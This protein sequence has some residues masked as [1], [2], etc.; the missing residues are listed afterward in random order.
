MV[1]GLAIGVAVS[2][3]LAVALA[4]ARH[5]YVRAVDEGAYA[6]FRG[7]ENG[8][9]YF[10]I[11]I[12]SGLWP[13]TLLFLTGRWF[14]TAVIGRPTPKQRAYAANRE[15]LVQMRAAV[16]AGLIDEVPQYLLDWER[17]LGRLR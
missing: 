6:W 9:S 7:M 8:D 4:V 14:G 12:C 5:E 10:E 15:A 13:I 3:Y 2:A 1:E 11:A 17:D 16:K